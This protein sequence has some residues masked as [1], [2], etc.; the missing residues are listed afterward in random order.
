MIDS[1]L[2]KIRDKIENANNLETKS[3]EQLLELLTSLETEITEFA[4]QN[5]EGAE[6]I[7]LF[8]QSSA[9]EITKEKPDQALQKLSLEGLSRSVKE[10]E[11]THPK[12]TD[13]V[14]Q[15]CQMLAN[16]GI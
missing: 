11:V 9:H 5:R 15:F 7:A 3:K 6:S 8:S 13:A 10:F 12:L 14:N 16:L 4:K 1:T 2:Q